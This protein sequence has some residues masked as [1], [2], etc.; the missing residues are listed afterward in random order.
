MHNII[1]TDLRKSNID[2][3][4]KAK[5][6]RLFWNFCW[7]FLFSI[8]P[9]RLG[10]SW[11]IFLLRFFGTRIHGEALILPSCR[12]LQPWKL[13]L[14]DGVAIGADVNIYNYDH[15]VIGAMSVVSQDSYLCTGSHDYTDYTM[16]LIWAPITIGSECWLAAGVFVSPG[17]SIS[18]GTVIGARS[19]VT[20]DMPAWTVCA[21]NPCKPIKPRVL[22]AN[23]N[24][25]V[26]IDSDQK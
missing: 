14:Y 24:S 25:S 16:P 11:R 9:K 6:C 17:V 13:E 18:N 8:T 23:E 4:F 15:V 7:L 22:K 10:N 5:V 3:P 26:N 21:G 20:K 19:V 12:I 1:V 2:W